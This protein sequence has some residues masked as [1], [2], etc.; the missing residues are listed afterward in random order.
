MVNLSECT[1]REGG[2]LMARYSLV[3]A[4]LLLFLVL[5]GGVTLAAETNA[6][7]PPT[8]QMPTSGVKS[9]HITAKQESS[10]EINGTRYALHPKVEFASE[11]GSPLE[12][13]EFKKGDRV[14]Y[15]LKGERIDVLVL[16]LP[17]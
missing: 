6:S 1:V 13:K 17:K 3:W 9:G 5:P 10:V 8:F 15:H 11:E 16:E 2:R 12:W 4:V 14:H 7:G